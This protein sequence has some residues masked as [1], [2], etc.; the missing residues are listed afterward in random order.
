MF[1]LYTILIFESPF[2]ELR[3]PITNSILYVLNIGYII[4]MYLEFWTGYYDRKTSKIILKHKMIVKRYLTSYFFPDLFS[5]IPM[6]YLRKLNTQDYKL[7]IIDACLRRFLFDLR[8]CRVWVYFT[9]WM[10]AFQE[11]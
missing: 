11:V 3:D 4:N 5:L 8:L 6:I 7:R 2:N 9:E 10:K 1:I